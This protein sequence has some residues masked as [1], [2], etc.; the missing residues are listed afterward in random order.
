[1]SEGGGG[2]GGQFGEKVEN[3]RHPDDIN[4]SSANHGPRDCHSHD[5]LAVVEIVPV[6]GL[7]FLRNQG[8]VPAVFSLRQ[9]VSSQF[10]AVRSIPR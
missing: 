5:I 6:V 3:I 2:V 8:A 4:Y 7:H 10:K 9:A 1:M